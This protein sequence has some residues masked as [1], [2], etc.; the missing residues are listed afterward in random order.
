MAGTLFVGIGY[1]FIRLEFEKTYD[2]G[3]QFRDLESFRRD[4]DLEK[5][6]LDENFINE[7]KNRFPI[8]ALNR[9]NPG[10]VLIEN[11]IWKDLEVFVL[12]DESDLYN[13]RKRKYI[14]MYIKYPEMR[15]KISK[16]IG[17][18]LIKKVEYVMGSNYASIALEVERRMNYMKI[19]KE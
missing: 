10:S 12:G 8:K 18:Y 11:T 2:E 6:K 16:V 17:K 13:E 5:K 7:V 1:I 4:H 9:N 15:K 14:L 3:K 19:T